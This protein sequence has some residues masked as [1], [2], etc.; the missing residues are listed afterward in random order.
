MIVAYMHYRDMTGTD[1]VGYTWPPVAAPSTTV[2]HV[3]FLTDVAAVCCHGPFETV[4][5]LPGSW[6][7]RWQQQ[8]SGLGIS[9]LRSTTAGE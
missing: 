8:F 9:H 3:L 7:A 4:Y 2:V 1:Q 6:M 5:M